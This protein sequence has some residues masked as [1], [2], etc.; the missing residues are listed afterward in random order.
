[1]NRRDFLG[2][3]LAGAAGTLLARDRAGAAQAEPDPTALVPLGRHLKVC[4]VGAGTGM[5]G[6]NRSTNQ[7]RM[8]RERFEALLRYEYDQ[9]VR[10]FDCADL[11]GTHP[12][13]GRLLKG[14]PRDSFQII[15]KLWVHRDGLPE[16]ERPDADVCVARFLKELQMEYLDLVQF[17]S[18][19][20]GKWPAELRKQMDILAKLKEKGVIRAHGV[21]VHS[22]D[23]LRAAAAEPWV[24]VI[25]VR[26]N[27]FNA[28]TDGPME[29]VL[30]VVKEARAAGK[31]ILGMKLVGEGRF[32]PDQLAQS[33]RY[34]MGTGLVD[35]MIA[36]FETNTQVDQ[37]KSLVRDQLATPSN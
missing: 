29:R 1:M 31:G 35:A 33:V 13:V 18:I 4:R 27:P 24:D 20:S 8:G 3:A 7:T 15:T 26:V 21:S 6:W 19:A 2:A 36:G 34:V 16:R 25:H 32:N 10:L 28:V 5:R 22:V 12:H 17:H 30:P 37:F 9:G 14:K 11:Y 23:A